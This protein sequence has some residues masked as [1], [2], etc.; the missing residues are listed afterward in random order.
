MIKKVNS[1]IVGENEE[2]MYQT[3]LACLLCLAC[4]CSYMDATSSCG[5]AP[6]STTI[7]YLNSLYRD[8]FLI[9]T[10]F[11]TAVV[12]AM[13]IHLILRSSH[14]APHHVDASPGILLVV[15]IGLLICPFNIFYRSTRYC[16]LQVIRNITCSPF[17]KV[18]LVDFFMADQLTSQ[19]PLLRH[20]ESTACYFLAGSF[21]THQY[22]ASSPI[23]VFCDQLLW[24]LA[25]SGQSHYTF[26]RIF[27]FA[28]VQEDGE[29]DHLANM[30]KYVSTM[31]AAGARAIAAA[32]SRTI[33]ALLERLKLEY[34]V[35]GEKKNLCELIKTIAANQGLKGFWKGNFVNIL[36]TA[37]FKAVNFYAY[38]TYRKQL[39][40]V[41]RNEET[42]NFER[43]L[44]GAA[45]GITATIL[46]SPEQ[47]EL[48]PMRTL[49]YGAIAGTC[50]EA[51]T[52]PF[53]VVRRHL[54]MQVQATKL[55]ALILATCP[56]IVEQ[57]GIP[58]LYA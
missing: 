36:R 26:K 30:G 17:Y 48:G 52:Y 12:G 46:C 13:V 5:R 57:R 23:I 51:A 43:F 35:L 38:D 42:T 55:S 20:M 21:K 37:P 11:M 14:I 25:S 24:N 34:I 40:K 29:N 39:L 18:V 3:E 32:V 27:N 8:V 53:E 22:E 10:S 9:C 56:K 33:V 6:G 54:Q 45:A 16:F 47:M 41:S 15:S 50:A 44:A 2:D 58:A 31:L 28:S 1:T 49:L 7:S 4:T 19:I